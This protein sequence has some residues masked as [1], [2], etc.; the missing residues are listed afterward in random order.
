MEE[1]IARP[2]GQSEGRT[3]RLARIDLH[4]LEPVRAGQHSGEYKVPAGQGKCHK[5]AYH[6][7]GG[8][9]LVAYGVIYRAER[10]QQV[11]ELVRGFEGVENG[12]IYYQGGPGEGACLESKYVHDL[13]SWEAC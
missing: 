13:W 1:G 8:H 4:I 10:A 5:G 6:Q 12:Y 11:V 7:E 9:V 3:V 2:W